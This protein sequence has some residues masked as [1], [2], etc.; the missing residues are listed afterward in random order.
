MV[1]LLTLQIKGSNTKF[2]TPSYLP[3]GQK[4]AAYQG[5]ITIDGEQLLIGKSSQSRK[6]AKTLQ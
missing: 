5:T 2:S 4:S 1:K 6:E 3:P